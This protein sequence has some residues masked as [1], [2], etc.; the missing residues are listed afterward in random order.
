MLYYR[1]KHQPRQLSVPIVRLLTIGGLL[2][3][4]AGA[5]TVRFGET[6]A[7]TLF[8]YG[9]IAAA[10]FAVVLLTTSSIQRIVGAI[11]NQLDE[12][13]LRLRARAMS[14]A[15]TGLSALF[16]VTTIYLAIAADTGAWVPTTYDDFNGAFWGIFLWATLLPTLCLS[17]QLD[18]A[19]EQGEG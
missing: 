18:P 1:S 16:L 7:T 6:L 15:F 19:D 9:L 10:L 14:A 5:L 13:E 12:Y 8:G 4:P 2:A 17:F 11:P 3:Y